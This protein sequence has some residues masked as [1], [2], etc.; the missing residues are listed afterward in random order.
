[1]AAGGKSFL[2]LAVSAFLVGFIWIVAT[3][4]LEASERSRFTTWVL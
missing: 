1:M 2:A 4:A 3:K